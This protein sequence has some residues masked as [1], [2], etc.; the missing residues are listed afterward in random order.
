MTKGKKAS[1]IDKQ[2]ESVVY[3][4]FYGTRIDRAMARVFREWEQQ[5]ICSTIYRYSTYSVHVVGGT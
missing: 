1:T 3:V 2:Q 5:A 4:Y